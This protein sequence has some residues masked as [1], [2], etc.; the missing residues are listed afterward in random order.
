MYKF[1]NSP[2]FNYTISIYG[3]FD[4]IIQYAMY[5]N[6]SRSYQIMNICNMYT[7]YRHQ[8][9]LNDNFHETK[10]FS[11]KFLFFLLCRLFTLIIENSFQNKN[12]NEPK[13][14]S[15]HIAAN[16]TANVVLIV[17]IFFRLLSFAFYSSLS[18]SIVLVDHFE[19]LQ[20]AGLGRWWSLFN[21]LP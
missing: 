18:F 1:D 2:L 10:M 6:Q 21:V 14:H 8:I 15:F 9:W 17:F 11:I 13:Y 4:I 20:I 12:K 7:R 16:D 3:K 5:S 19:W